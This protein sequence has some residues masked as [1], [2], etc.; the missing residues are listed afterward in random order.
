MESWLAAYRAEVRPLYAFVS[1]RVGAD[2]D[3]AEDVVQETFLRALAAWRRK[4]PP[5]APAAWLR[6]AAT[7]LIRNHYRSRRPDRLP[8]GFDLDAPELGLASPGHAALVQWGLARLRD[9]QARLLEAYHLDGREVRA[10]AA[11]HGLTER[12]VEGRLRRAR[13]ALRAHLAP[14]VEGERA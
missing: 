13:L 9:G 10:I 8:A 14:H 12:A 11:E 6:T 4:G 2:R 5:R 1:R 7:N 3:L